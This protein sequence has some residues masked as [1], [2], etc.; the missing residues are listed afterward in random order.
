MTDDI[1]T[2]EKKRDWKVSAILSV[3]W[4]VAILIARQRGIGIPDS[5]LAIATVFFFLL[6]PAMNDL[7][8][9]IERSFG[10]RSSGPASK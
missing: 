1:T 6:I 2:T 8:A 7:V 3:I 10:D 9:A 5:M 4:V